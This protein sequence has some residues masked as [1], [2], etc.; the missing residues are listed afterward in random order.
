M[1][2]LSVILCIISTVLVI[3][4]AIDISI[5]SYNQENPSKEPTE[6]TDAD[7]MTLYESW[8]VKHGKNYNALG[9]KERRFGVFK[10]NLRYI[11]DHNTQN[12][13][14][15]LGLNRF[16]DLTNEEYRSMYLGTRMDNRRRSVRSSNRYA[17][18]EGD[19]LPESVDW[20]E[21]GAVVPV[22]DQ[23]SC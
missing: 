1:A 21:K 15:K 18:R 10:D 11:D 23:G 9:E 12:R 8:L 4:S 6:R 22:K 13:S 3:S 2:Y 14:F 19:S 16:A 7:V 17:F 5:V 20:R